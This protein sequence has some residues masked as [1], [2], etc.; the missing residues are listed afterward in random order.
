MASI[1]DGMAGVLNTTFGAP[2][3]YLPVSGTALSVQSVFREDP[4][5]I[6]G[7]NGQD[8]L[9][10]APSW[11][12]PKSVLADVRRGDRISL[13]DGRMFKVLNRIGTGSPAADAF[14]LYELELMP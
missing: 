11:R 8:V 7:D 9:V 14:M 4:I 10:E 12:V 3:T 13:P 1:F 6:T 2:I 5:T